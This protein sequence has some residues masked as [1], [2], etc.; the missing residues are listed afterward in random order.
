MFAPQTPPPG[1]LFVTLLVFMFMM[2][3]GCSVSGRNAIEITNGV[4]SLSSAGIIDDMYRC[5]Y[6][7]LDTIN[8]G[9]G[10]HRSK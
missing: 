3:T 1:L 2:T 6:D 8:R 9:S 7:A 4:R 5:A 10:C